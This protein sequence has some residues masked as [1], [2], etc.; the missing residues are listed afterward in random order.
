MVKNLPWNAGDPGS[1]PGQGTK[2]SHATE[3]LNLLITAREPAR[4]NERSCMME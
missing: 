2:L 3:Q 1:I 4:Q